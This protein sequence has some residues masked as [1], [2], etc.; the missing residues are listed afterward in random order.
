MT[1]ERVC[2]GTPKDK[3][4]TKLLKTLVDENHRNGAPLSNENIQQPVSIVMEEIEA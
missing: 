1:Y 4:Y 3:Y 2:M